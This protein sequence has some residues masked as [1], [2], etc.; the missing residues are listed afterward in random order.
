MLALLQQDFVMSNDQY[1][2]IKSCLD[3]IKAR[4]DEV[5]DVL[6]QTRLF[7]EQKKQLIELSQRKLR[8]I[9]RVDYFDTTLISASMEE[10]SLRKHWLTTLIKVLAMI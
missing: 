5:S 9:E 10:I 3:D 8:D 6:R 1:L 7:I 4:N 2:I